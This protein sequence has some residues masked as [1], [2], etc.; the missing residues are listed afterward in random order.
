MKR[1]YL[2]FAQNNQSTNYLEL[3]YLQALSIK[4][5]QSINSYSV[6]VDNQTHS[7]IED[8]HRRVFDL[9]I[10]L[11]QDYAVDQSWKLSNEWQAGIHSPYDHTVKLESDIIFTSNIDSWWDIMAARDLCFTVSVKNYRGQTSAARDYRKLFD[12]NNLPNVYNGFY[13]F[14]KSE[15]AD[16]FFHI[17]ELIFKNWNQVKSFLKNCN[18]NTPTTDV[19]FAIAAKLVGEENC[20]L[21]SIEVPCFTHMKGAINDWDANQDWREMVYHQFDGT[22][23][24]VG[25]TRQRVP[26]HYYQ[27]DFASPEL[28]KYYESILHKKTKV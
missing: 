2:T 3:A 11:E 7:Q 15:F 23:L 1:G 28:I 5:T 6:I 24:T 8:R 18:D 20:F 12:D 4:A 21:P 17:A 27:K 9:I 19:V 26:F 22:N 14:K 13:F 10:V 16:Q 25:F